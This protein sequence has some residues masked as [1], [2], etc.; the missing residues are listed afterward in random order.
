MHICIVDQGEIYGG[1]ECF[2]LDYIKAIYGQFD[3]SL[4][5]STRACDAYRETL[6]QFPKVRTHMLPMYSLRLT[7]PKSVLSFLCAVVKLI[8]YVKKEKVTYL[9]SNTVRGHMIASIASLCTGVPLLWMVHDLTFAPFFLKKL[10]FI[11]KKIAGVSP[12]VQ[13]YVEKYVSS[14]DMKK[15]CII[16]NGVFTNVPLVATKEYLQD[17]NNA[18]FTFEAG[19]RY[20]SII[21]RVDTWKGQDVFLRAIAYLAETQKMPANI[22]FLVVGDV[23][24]TSQERIAYGEKLHQFVVEKELSSYVTFLGHQPIAEIL[25][26]TTMLVQAST[27][28]ETFGRT[29][30]EGFMA[31]VPVISSFLGAAKYIISYGKTGLTFLPG[32]HE[33]LAHKILLLLE[34]TYLYNT[35]VQHARMEVEQKYSMKHVA[36]LFLSIFT[37]DSERK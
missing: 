34:D 7:S 23:T 28:P 6:A 25:P 10:S 16:P 4:C 11:P 20:I 35:I 17:I 32:N 22:H 21:G 33:D 24:K 19:I 37:E 15:F 8:Y 12:V 18:T 9:Y 1:A 27:A 3:L 2:A 29:I 36:E 26:H 30:I 5:L 31:G 14:E 13:E